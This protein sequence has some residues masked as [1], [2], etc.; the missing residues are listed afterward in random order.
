[1]SKSHKIIFKNLSLPFT[2][3]TDKIPHTFAVWDNLE[4]SSQ[5]L[6]TYLNCKKKLLI[7][8]SSNM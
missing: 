1:M 6:S 3:K 7:W 2:S 4:I 8:Y 5:E